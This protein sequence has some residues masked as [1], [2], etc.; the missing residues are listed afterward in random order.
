MG[1]ELECGASDLR[2][3]LDATGSILGAAIMTYECPTC[4]A[5]YKDAR[6]VPCCSACDPERFA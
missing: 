4:G 3:D 5:L 1:S 2:R 6:P